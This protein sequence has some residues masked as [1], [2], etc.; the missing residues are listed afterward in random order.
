MNSLFTSATSILSAVFMASKCCCG[1][2]DILQNAELLWAR[3]RRSGTH[4]E[5]HVPIISTG[6]SCPPQKTDECTKQMTVYSFIHEKFARKYVKI[7][8]MATMDHRNFSSENECGDEMMLGEH[9]K[10]S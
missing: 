6:I 9:P 5:A 3:I 7:K 1:L 10:T 8:L 2:F 4:T